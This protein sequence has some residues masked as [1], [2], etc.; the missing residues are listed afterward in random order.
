MASMGSGASAEMQLALMEEELKVK[1]E[2][3]RERRATLLLAPTDRMPPVTTPHP[4]N[5]S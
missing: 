5:I 3:K 4:S 1:E 2:E